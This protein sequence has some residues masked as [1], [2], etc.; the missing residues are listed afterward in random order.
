MTKLTFA[1]F[2]SHVPVVIKA[3]DRIIYCFLEDQHQKLVMSSYSFESRL[4]LSGILDRIHQQRMSEDLEL[5]DPLE[6]RHNW[7][8]REKWTASGILPVMAFKQKYN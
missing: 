1:R 3:D 2:V 8:L 5:Q 6:L 4:L 7:L